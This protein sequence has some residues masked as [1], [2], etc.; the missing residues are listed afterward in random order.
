MTQYKSRDPLFNDCDHAWIAETLISEKF[1]LAKP[2]KK[3]RFL[4]KRISTNML[5]VENEL[6]ID[7]TDTCNF[8][9]AS[10]IQRV[11]RNLVREFNESSIVFRLVTWNSDES[12]LRELTPDERKV[13]TG[14]DVLLGHDPRIGLTDPVSFTPLLPVNCKIF[15]PELATQTM[16]VKRTVSLNEYS[17]NSLY[18]I[19]YDAVPIILP[20]TTS[21]GMVSAFT[22][23][24]ELLKRCE[25]IF[26]ISNSTAHEFSELLSGLS[27]QG[28]K[29][30]KVVPIPL[31]VETDPTNS[32]VNKLTNAE[33][34]FLVVGSH[35]P[36]KNHERIL[37]AAEMLWQ[38]G[39]NFEMNFVGSRGWESESFW[40]LVSTLEARGRKLYCHTGIN[41]S[42]L[43]A[44]YQSS[45]ALLSFSI[46]E[47]YGLPIAESVRHNL[48][49]ITVNFGSQGE[50]AK[51]Y[52]LTAIN[53]I[54]IDAISSAMEAFLTSQKLPKRVSPSQESSTYP[55]SWREY[56]NKISQNII[57]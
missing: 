37:A 6:L 36:R 7:V 49:V 12:V 31:P 19:G 34:R 21:T 15:I 8:N 43:I 45:S 24:L 39:L 14:E 35:E 13:A 30:P 52:N 18:A 29:P 9:I 33:N 56:F 2:E 26:A 5:V 50:I 54:T 57:E 25:M 42:E 53:E 17:N 28:K 16:R 44:L 51:A 38:R 3:N 11:V 47:G 1:P 32:V 48:P 46:H 4:E 10:G 41:D 22:V 20:D 23:Q 55:D 27:S 40:E